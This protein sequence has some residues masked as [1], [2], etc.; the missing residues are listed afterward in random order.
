MITMELRHIRYFLAVA[1]EQSFTRAAARL[2]ISQPP[3]SMQIKS[4]EEEVGALLFN[5]QADGVR[6]TCAGEAFLEAVQR[7]PAVVARAGEAARHAAGGRY[8]GNVVVGL[9]IAPIPCPH[10]YER[11]H[12]FRCEHPGAIIN[13]EELSAEDLLKAIRNQRIDV[14]IMRGNDVEG[15]HSELVLSRDRLVLAEATSRAQSS[16]EVTDEI[17]VVKGRQLVIPQRRAEPAIHDAGLLA[18]RSL[19]AGAPEVLVASGLIEALLHVSMDEGVAVLPST[20]DLLRFPGI[21]C[22][23]LIPIQHINLVAINVRRSGSGLATGLIR[24][25]GS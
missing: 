1:E 10:L 7:I 12:R 13:L 5:R 21:S 16:R 19:Y 23:A 3:L 4:L 25:L 17:T 14:A 9:A 24:A 8:E 15:A 6:L 20:V 22:R 11:R 18:S 2:G